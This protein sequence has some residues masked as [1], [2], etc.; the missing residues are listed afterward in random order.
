MSRR[1]GALAGALAAAV[2][3]AVTSLADAMVRS[4]PSLIGAVAQA[5]LRAAPAAVSK[6]AI[7]TLGHADKPALRIGTVVIA[8]LIGAAAGAVATRHRWVG[9]AAF[10]AFGG[11]G[12]VCVASLDGMPLAGALVSAVLAAAAGALVLRLLLPGHAADVEEASA[13][14][15]PGQGV[16]RRR[17]LAAAG[18]AVAAVAGARL[19]SPTQSATVATATA[20]GPAPDFGGLV[21]NRGLSVQGLSPLIT[22]SGD[23]YRTDEALIIPSVNV[24][25]WRLRVD[26]MVERPFELT[27]DQLLALDLVEADVTLACVSNEVGGTLVGNGRWTG[28]RLDALLERAGVRPTADQIVGRSVDGFT[29]GFPTTTLDGRDALVAVAMNGEALTRV[30]G[31][32]AR[33][34]V[35]GLYGYVSA[36]KWLRQIEATTFAAFD[37]YWVRRTWAQRGPIKLESRV[38]VPRDATTV[39]GGRQPIAGVA[40][41]PHRGIAKVE[42]RV[43]GG[44]WREA[45]LGPS[46]GNDAWRQW[47]LTWDATRGQHEIEVRATAGDGEVQT[48]QTR[49]PYP[50][51]AT[52]HHRVRVEVT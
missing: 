48:P 47:L 38:D 39:S 18:T 17:F 51:G 15:V 52:G 37:A 45:Q 22:S 13:I 12:V 46:L 44:A 8:L 27:Y 36:T 31:Y 6:W 14:P 20:S 24:R 50:D 29:A 16:D 32:P 33:L 26:G 10:A 30:R 2:A 42:V 23:F 19:A 3:L 4:V 35:P 40:W 5:F 7:E 49:A 43:D 21:T 41:A 25:S 1:T 9:G 28:V 11:L 34:V